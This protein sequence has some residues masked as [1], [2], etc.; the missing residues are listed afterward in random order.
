MPITPTPQKKRSSTPALVPLLGLLLLL[1]STAPALHA[2]EALPSWAI[3]PFTRRVDAQPVI[4]PNTNSLFAC[5]LSGTNVS[6]EYHHTF[7]PAAITRDGKIIVLYRAE[8]IVAGNDSEKKGI[9][10]Y[11]SRFGYGASTDGITFERDPHPVYYPAQDDQ[12]KYEWTGGCEDPRLAEGPDGTYVV[13]YTQYPSGTWRLGIASSKDLKTWTKHGSPFEGTPFAKSKV[14][15]AAIVHEVKD[16]KLVAAKINGKF[17]M[18]FGEHEVMIASSDDL[19]HWTPVQGPDGK[20]LII[21]KTRDGYFDSALTE[22]GPQSILTK[23]GIVV[24]YNGKN[25]NP[26][27]NGDPTLSSGVYTC[28]QALFDK[29]DPTKYVTRLD[30][31]FFKPELDWEKSGQYKAGTTFAEGLTLFKNTWYLYYGCADTF[32]G[33]A[34][35]PYK[36]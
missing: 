27:R 25:A 19:I 13:T 30:H 10:R 3:G 9:G 2:E 17:W 6:W 20:M 33:V 12:Q 11:T 29:N 35:A 16:G 21:M 7:N 28:G 32:V 23:D 8:G 36:P 5:P 15:S 26:T 14:K 22:I 1:A 24:T 4:R 18:Y 31:P 34:T